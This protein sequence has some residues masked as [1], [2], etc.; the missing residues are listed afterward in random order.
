MVTMDEVC[1]VTENLLNLGFIYYPSIP[2][3]SV[4]TTINLGLRGTKSSFNKTSF[5]VLKQ[6]YSI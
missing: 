2:G 4:D 3:F 6:T 5:Y 1:L